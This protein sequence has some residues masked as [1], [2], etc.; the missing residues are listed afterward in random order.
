MTLFNE[1]RWKLIAKALRFIGGG[2]FFTL[3]TSSFALIAYF[4]I[5]RPHVPQPQYDWT[6]CLEWSFSH[7]TYGNCT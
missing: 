3:L 4:A 6:V 5:T 2:G 7:P 1:R